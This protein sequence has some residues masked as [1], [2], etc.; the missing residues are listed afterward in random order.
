VDCKMNTREKLA[1]FGADERERVRTIFVSHT[2]AYSN[3]RLL[4]RVVQT[5]G[6]CELDS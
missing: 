5:H 2:L 4:V 3:A 1:E 6:L